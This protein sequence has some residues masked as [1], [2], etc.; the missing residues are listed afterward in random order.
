[1]VTCQ[2]KAEKYEVTNT[3]SPY[4]PPLLLSLKFLPPS[5]CVYLLLDINSK[6]RDGRLTKPVFRQPSFIL[7]SRYKSLN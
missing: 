6:P 7:C 4:P 3:S 2:V 1:M 5:S